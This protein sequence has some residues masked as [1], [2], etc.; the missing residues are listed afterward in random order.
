MVTFLFP[1]LNQAEHQLRGRAGADSKNGTRVTFFLKPLIHTFLHRLIIPLFQFRISFFVSFSFPTTT[2]LSTVRWRR[3]RSV[4][5]SPPWERQVQFFAQ[6]L[7][8][9]L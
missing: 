8:T 4:L 1:D 9:F 6:T 2:H 7:L 5:L 3:A